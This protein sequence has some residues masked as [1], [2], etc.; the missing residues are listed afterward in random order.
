MA[1]CI[2]EHDPQAELLLD[3]Q[4]PACGARWQLVLDIVAFLWEELCSSAAG[5][6][7]EVD[8]LARA[9]AWSEREIL[10]LSPTRR[11]LYVEM[12]S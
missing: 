7:G 12:A 1:A 10:A 5:L 11:R 6:L 2:A 9:Y 4:C 3:L 8:T